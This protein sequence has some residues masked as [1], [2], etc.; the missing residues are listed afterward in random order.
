MA[1][2]KTGAATLRGSK[3]AKQIAVAVLETLSGELCTTEAAAK[4]GVSLSRYYQLETRALQGL[5][6]AVEP[7]AKGPQKTPEREIKALRGEKKLLEKELRR[8]QALLRAAQRSV[9]L[10]GAG[11]KKASSKKRVRAKRGSRG[12]TVLQTLRRDTDE[13]EGGADGT[14]KRHAD[15]GGDDRGQ[16]A[17]A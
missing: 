5:L 8:H 16:P 17:G 7:R 10:P 1:R 4:L 2:T 9:G 13:A 3:R 11:S 14:E 12:Q 6:E 15:V